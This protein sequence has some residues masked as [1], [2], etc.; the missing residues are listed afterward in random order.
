MFSSSRKWYVLPSARPAPIPPANPLLIYVGAVHIPKVF[1][2]KLLKSISLEIFR[3]KAVEQL[4]LENLWYVH[5]TH[6]NK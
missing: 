4:S 1:E 5:S 3:G 2:G 6:I